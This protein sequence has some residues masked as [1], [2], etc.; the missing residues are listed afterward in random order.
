MQAATAARPPE[1]LAPAGDP[2]AADSGDTPRESSETRALRGGVVKALLAVVANV[3]VL[4]ALLVYFG[5]VRSDRFA[6]AL[7]ID[8]AILGMTVDDYLRRSVQS[9]FILPLAAAGTGL[10]WVAF[11]QW[12]RRRR[13]LGEDDRVAVLVARWLWTV[14]VGIFALGIVLGLVGY[15]ATFIAAPLVCAAG[16]LLLLYALNLRAVLPDATPFA[17]L[18]DGVLRGSIA[19]LVAIG[20]FW[21]ATNFAMVEGTQI[22]QA[23]P[24]RVS[25]LPSLEVDSA[26]PLDIVAPGVS[27]S[28]P[29]DEGRTRYHYRGL[30]YLESTGGNYFLVSDGW[31]PDYG[32][33]VILPMTSEGIRYT[34]VRDTSGAARAAEYPPCEEEPS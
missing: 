26:E 31:T 1:T 12:W 27:M 34:F 15:A 17:P 3:G 20:L 21:S 29:E 4:T 2:D 9:V 22:A 25:Q 19:V 10:A 6:S 28:C 32:V 7:G 33:V 23:F 14:A 18:T 13:R 8:E 30:K 16:L 5:W 24:S 11:D